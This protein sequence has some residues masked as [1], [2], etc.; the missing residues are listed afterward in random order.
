[1]HFENLCD[2]KFKSNELID[3]ME[4]ISR[5]TDTESVEMFLLITVIQIQCIKQG[6]KTYKMHVGEI[7]KNNTRNLDIIGK[8]CAE[9]EPVIIK[10]IS[11]MK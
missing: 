6:R 8:A 5:Q 11:A 1:M 4:K 10:E 9:R 3:L 2:T 7:K